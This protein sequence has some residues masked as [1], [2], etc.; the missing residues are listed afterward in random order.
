MPRRVLWWALRSVGVQEWAV[1]AIPSNELLQN[2][3]LHDVNAVLRSRRL[4]WSGHVQRATSCIKQITNLAVPS[5]RGRGRPRKTWAECVRKD[6]DDLGLSGVNLQDKVA[7]RN[8]VPH[9]LLVQPTPQY[10]N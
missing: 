3:G 5:N 4:R 6:M 2:L 10:E 1:R 8:V 9:S 7:W